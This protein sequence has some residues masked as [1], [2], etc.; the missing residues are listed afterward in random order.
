MGA[1]PE[2]L[3][4]IAKLLLGSDL[5]PELPSLWVLIGVT[6]NWQPYLARAI[7]LGPSFLLPLLHPP[8]R[9]S[10]PAI[11]V[12]GKERRKRLAPVILTRLD[13]P[14]ILLG[15]RPLPVNPPGVLPWLEGGGSLW[16]STLEMQDFAALSLECSS[17]MANLLILRDA[18]GPDTLIRER[19]GYVYT[20]QS[21]PVIRLIRVSGLRRLH[22]RLHLPASPDR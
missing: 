10:D 3:L 14:K 1:D 11:D 7:R 18:V 5:A 22:P 4:R 2:E 15:S 9:P 12:L 19:W 6:R 21:Q 13:Y 20:R 16:A 8:M 17:I